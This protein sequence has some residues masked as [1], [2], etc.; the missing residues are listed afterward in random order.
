MKA[1]INNGKR[2]QIY[3]DNFEYQSL[4]KF[5]ARQFPRMRNVNL[6]FQDKTGHQISIQDQDDLENMKKVY[7]GQNFVEILI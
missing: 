5:I 1:I 7:Q 4:Q 6:S 2:T 3:S